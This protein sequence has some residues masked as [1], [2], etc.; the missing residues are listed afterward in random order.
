[1]S[2]FDTADFYDCDENTE[3]LHYRD[4]TD[5]L[6][7]HLDSCYLSE[8]GDHYEYPDELTVYAWKRTALAD[9][10]KQWMADRLFDSLKE[11]HDGSEYADPEESVKISAVAANAVGSAL[12]AAVDAF[13]SHVTVWSCEQVAERAYT[14]AEM[15]TML[16]TGARP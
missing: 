10:D 14:E 11:L 13:Y 16:E 3:R 6:E 15:R 4:P 2:D 7:N 8:S 1:M 5:A 9:A 12:R